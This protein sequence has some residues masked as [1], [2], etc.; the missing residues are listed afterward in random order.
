LWEGSALW[1]AGSLACERA[2]APLAYELGPSVAQ[3]EK[4]NRGAALFAVAKAK[5]GIKVR[6]A[7][8]GRRLPRRYI[9]ED[10]TN[11]SANPTQLS[12]SLHIQLTSRDTF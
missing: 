2:E 3:T 12:T 6:H 8:A 11:P 7:K 9:R 4:L 1:L 5:E 10:K